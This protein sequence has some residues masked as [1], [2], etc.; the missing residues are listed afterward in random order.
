MMPLS[1]QEEFYVPE[2]SEDEESIATTEYSTHSMAT[3]LLET[4]LDSP[5]GGR[6]SESSQPR[7]GRPGSQ[8]PSSSGGDVEPKASDED[9][10]VKPMLPAEKKGKGVGKKS[11]ANTAKKRYSI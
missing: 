7:G 9:V 2:F 3:R 4:T 11:N 8:V 5:C 1:R 6:Q 10:F